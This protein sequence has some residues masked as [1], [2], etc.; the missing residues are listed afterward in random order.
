MTCSKSSSS[1]KLLK[2]V[3]ISIGFSTGVTSELFT[4]NWINSSSKRANSF[5]VSIPSSH[6][7]SAAQAQ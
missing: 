1:S 7:S 6:H 5:S 2:T 4:V 3:Q